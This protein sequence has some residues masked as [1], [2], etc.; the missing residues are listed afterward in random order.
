MLVKLVTIYDVSNL[1]GQAYLRAFVPNNIINSFKCTR[2]FPFN[3][4][5]FTQIDLLAANVTDRPIV[6]LV[7]LMIVIEVETAPGNLP[8]TSFLFHLN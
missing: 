1:V 2:F 5:I 4:N 6:K 7:F 3:K 8:S